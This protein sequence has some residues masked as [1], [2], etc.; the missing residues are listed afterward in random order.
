MLSR[1][2]VVQRRGRLV[3]SGP[4][5]P[6]HR[7]CS[8]SAQPHSSAVSSSA[9]AAPASTPQARHAPARP[10]ARRRRAPVPCRRNRAH[11][12]L[13]SP[14]AAAPG[15]PSPPSVETQA[16]RRRRSRAAACRR[17]AHGD[18]AAMR[19]FDVFAAQDLD[20]NGIGHDA[21]SPLLVECLEQ[22]RRSPWSGSPFATLAKHYIVD[23]QPVAFRHELQP[24]GPV[25]VRRLR[26]KIVDLRPR[27][28]PSRR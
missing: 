9:G 5:R 19:A 20:K 1:A 7:D 26:K 27:P 14:P 13:R 17:V 23:Q 8:A 28:G 25:G 12:P 10:G 16:A 22:H 3:R 24:I 6:S 15:S 2:I 18:R 4:A 21:A 11:P